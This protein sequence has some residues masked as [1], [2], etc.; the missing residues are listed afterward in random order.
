M[1][2]FAYLLSIFF[3]LSAFAGSELWDCKTTCKEKKYK[4]AMECEHCY[5]PK[6]EYD[7]KDCLPYKD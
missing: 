6:K 1:K 7:C 3:S 5:P 4:E 2:V